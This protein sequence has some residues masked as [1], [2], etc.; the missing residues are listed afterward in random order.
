[1]YLP[2]VF[3]EANVLQVSSHYEQSQE[4]VIEVSGHIG[5]ALRR[6]VFWRAESYVWQSLRQKP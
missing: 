2:L 4:P 3:H 1:M 5:I 6:V